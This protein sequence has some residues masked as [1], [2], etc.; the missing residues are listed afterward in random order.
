[1]TNEANA[2]VENLKSYFSQ[3]NDVKFALLF[4]STI[5]D[6]FHDTSDIDIAIDFS[7]KDENNRLDKWLTMRAELYQL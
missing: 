7:A 5:K 1:M 4:G 2:I 3:K 6:S